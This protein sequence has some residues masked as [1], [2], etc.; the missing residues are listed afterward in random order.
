MQELCNGLILYHGS[1]CEV[2]KPLLEKC[3]KRK[4][5]G[6]GFYLTSSKE[7]AESFLR[8]SIVKAVNNKD[9]DPDQDYGFISTFR[10][11]LSGELESHIFET[12]DIDWL[13][14]IAAHRKRESFVEIEEEM[15]KKEYDDFIH[16]KDESNKLNAMTNMFKLLERNGNE[17]LEYSSHI[18]DILDT[19]TSEDD[20]GFEANRLL[21]NYLSALGMF[22]DY[23][24]KHNKKHFGKE[25]MEEFT[26]K[27]HAFYDQHI[28]YRFT[29]L[30]RNYAL[31]Y[32]FPLT[33]IIKSEN[34]KSGIFA[35]KNKLLQFKSWKHAKADIE[36]MSND[37]SLEIHIKISMLFVKSLYDSYVYDVAPQVLKG[38]EYFAKLQS[39]Q[40]G[41]LPV[42]L[43]YQTINDLSEGNFSIDYTEPESYHKSLEIIKNHPSITLNF[44]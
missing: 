13:H 9:A 10:V 35:S 25:K 40:K 42:L 44:K 2:S 27:T 16:F 4:D 28:S 17:Y 39:K 32:A 18:Q 6:K 30:L 22:I 8:T 24:E 12:A 36:K 20:I 34:R 5:F 31:H 19:D 26:K 15:S 1:Y 7:Q 38:I 41:K 3:A 14:C 43:S 11:E 37:I 23:G 21:I 33:N 29:A